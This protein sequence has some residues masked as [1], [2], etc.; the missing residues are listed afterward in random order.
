MA[1]V[2]NAFNYNVHGRAGFQAL[3]KIVGC[4]A[5]HE[6]VYGRA[7]GSVAVFKQLACATP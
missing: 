1:L 2:D 6:F 5:C 4:C 3:A 7:A